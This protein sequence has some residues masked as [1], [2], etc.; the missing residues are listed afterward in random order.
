MK[1]KYIKPVT[2]VA[3]LRKDETL[4]SGSL[5]MNNEVGDKNQ[6]SKEFHWDERINS[7]S[8]WN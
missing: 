1:T 4:L 5:K 2:K 7:D 3:A 8:L 6:R